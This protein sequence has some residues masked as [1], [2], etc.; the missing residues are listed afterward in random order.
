M[1][2]E[3]LLKLGLTLIKVLWSSI[4]LLLPA[5]QVLKSYNQG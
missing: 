4:F 3:G 5:F 1:H 2:I